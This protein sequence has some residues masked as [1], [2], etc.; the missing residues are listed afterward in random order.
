MK[1]RLDFFESIP[2]VDQNVN[3][4]RGDDLV[5]EIIESSDTATR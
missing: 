4:V 5:E 3:R 1:L 2:R